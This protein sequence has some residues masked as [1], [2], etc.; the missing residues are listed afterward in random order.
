MDIDLQQIT[1]DLDY[2]KDQ[3]A[4][5]QFEL[6]QVEKQIER[7][8]LTLIAVLNQADVQEM[9]FAN[10]TFGLKTQQRTA[11]N[12][13]LLKEKYRDIYDKCYETTESQK[14]FFKVN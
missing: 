2:H 11:L 6:K 4:R 14:F 7:L 12:Q 1:N 3:K 5:L 8:E 10:Y 13:Q 9:N